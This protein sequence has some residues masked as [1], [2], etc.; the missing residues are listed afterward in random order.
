M[1]GP[2]QG[3]DSSV[4]LGFASAIRMP[5]IRRVSIIH[6]GA[7]SLQMESSAALSLIKRDVFWKFAA[8][9]RVNP[10]GRHFSHDA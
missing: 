6:I 1:K 9:P 2:E 4:V 7:Q 10:E 5:L 3:Y 8:C